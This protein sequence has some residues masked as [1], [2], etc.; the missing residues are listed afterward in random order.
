[1]VSENRHAEI[2]PSYAEK[3]ATGVS[4]VGLL[5]GAQL[6]ACP[7]RAQPPRLGQVPQ[8]CRPDTGHLFG[9]SFTLHMGSSLGQHSICLQNLLVCQVYSTMAAQPLA[10]PVHCRPQLPAALSG[11]T[12][13]S[14]QTERQASS[15]LSH[16]KVSCEPLVF[17]T[18]SFFLLFKLKCWLFWVSSD[19]QNPVAE[20]RSSPPRSPGH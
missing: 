6:P 17:S 7:T 5:S 13:L 20:P 14:S 15:C 4:P 8:P 12:E 1:M 9:S 2:P 10:C 3:P 16:S 18:A 11:W 19:I